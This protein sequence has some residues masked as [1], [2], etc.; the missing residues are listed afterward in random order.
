MN[1]DEVEFLL[2]DFD[3]G[4]IDNPLIT[5]IPVDDETMTGVIVRATEADDIG[6]V[7]SATV[8]EFFPAKLPLELYKEVSLYKKVGAELNET[9][10]QQ[11]VV[12]CVWVA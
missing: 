5:R 2:N 8:N 12:V 10:R 4:D 6:K 1:T 9:L 7:P 3:V 11:P